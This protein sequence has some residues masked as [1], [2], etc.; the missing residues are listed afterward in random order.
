MTCIYNNNESNKI[1]TILTIYRYVPY[2]DGMI[3]FILPDSLEN[4]VI[5]QSNMDMK[6]KSQFW[7]LLYAKLAKFKE[8]GNPRI[9]INLLYIKGTRKIEKYHSIEYIIGH[10]YEAHFDM[11]RLVKIECSN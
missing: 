7:Q 6:K 2:T 5:I 8:M 11:N 3:I 9:Y 10:I 4:C 1:Y